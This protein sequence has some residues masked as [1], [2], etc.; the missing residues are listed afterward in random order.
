MHHRRSGFGNGDVL[1][2]DTPAHPDSTDQFTSTQKRKPAGNG[3]E[4]SIA[5]RLDL[6]FDLRWDSAIVAGA[7]HGSGGVGFAKGSIGAVNAGSVHFNKTHLIATGVHYANGHRH[8]DFLG[9]FH[10]SRK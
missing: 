10:R 4:F 9:F 3:D 8:L 1:F 2:A 6:L 7:A 5:G